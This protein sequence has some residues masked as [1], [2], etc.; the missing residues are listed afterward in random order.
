MALALNDEQVLLKKTARSFLQEKAPV[1]ALRELRDSGDET[2]FS[3]S[4]WKEMVDLGWSGI[5]IPEEYGGCDYGYVGLGIILEEC[6]RT[7]T[8]SPLVSTVLLGSTAVKLAGNYEQKEAILPAIAGGEFLMS[9]ALEETPQHAPRRISLSAVKTPD[10]NYRLNGKKL[11]VI[12][13]HVVDKFIVVARTSGQPTD[14]EGITLFLVD[15]TAPGVA[16]KRVRMV[17]SRNSANVTFTDVKVPAAAILGEL[18]KG[19]RQL[20]KVL[21]IA[22]IGLAAEMLGSTLEAFDRTIVYLKER[23]QFD[24]PI[25]TFQSL[26]HRAAKMFCEIELGKS[27][28]MKGLLTIDENDDD[29]RLPLMATVAKGKLCETIKLVTN[30]AVQMFGGMGMTDEQEI[31]LFM[32]RARVVQQ[33]FGD[34]NYQIDRFASIRGY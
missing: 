13:G 14:Q 19:Y 17:D 6:G 10:G 4:L 27:V 18:D 32:K 7:L 29:S 8:A 1:K 11:F 22:R 30:E 31:G 25:G 28:V 24:V 26:Q 9:L 21:D 20:D 34:L 15:A 23:K 3:R 33:T 2:G 5:A 12:D 16:V